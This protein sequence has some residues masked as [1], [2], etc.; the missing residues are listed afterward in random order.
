MKLS[1]LPPELLAE[2][3]HLFSAATVP[4]PAADLARMA[5]LIAAV[6]RVVALP[7]WQE[8]R[9]G[10]VGGSGTAA[11]VFMGYDFHLTGAG[12]QLIEINTNAGGG[13]LAALQAERNDVLD[14]YVAMFRAECG[15]RELKALAIVDEQPRLQYL[16]PEFLAFQRLFQCH[17]IA[18]VICDPTDLLRCNGSLWYAE[19]EETRLDLVYNRVTDFA[20]AE[21]AQIVLREAWL[22]NAAVVTPNPRH[23]ALYADKRNLVALTD[24]ALLASWGVDAETR[25]VLAAGIPRTELVDAAR[26]DDFW[27]RRKQLFFKPAAGFGSRA[28]YRGDKLTRRVFEEILAGDYVAQALALPSTVPVEVAGEMTQLKVDLRN[29]VYRGEVQFIAARLYRGQTTNFRTP[30]GGFAKVVAA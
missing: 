14:A 7:A 23:H 6:E 3:P 24:A 13:F 17:G 29:Y 18:A 25:R 15:G 8:E 30:G 2:R 9:V 26:A 10:K 12:P 19:H 22:Q 4:V 21:D 27:A 1:D 5:E 11:G 20:L 28:A 16:Y